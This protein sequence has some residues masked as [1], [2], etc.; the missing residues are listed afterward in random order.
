MYW[1]I[2]KCQYGCETISCRVL[3]STLATASA[4]VESSLRYSTLVPVSAERLGPG[5]DIEPHIAEE[6]LCG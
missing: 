6:L 2:I 4:M 3:A 5:P 1:Y